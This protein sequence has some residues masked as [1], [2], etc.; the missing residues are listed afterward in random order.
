MDRLLEEVEVIEAQ[1]DPA[2]TE[3]TAI[4]FDSRRVGPGALFCC[5]PGRS[6]DGHDHAAAAVARGATALLTER[7]LVLDVT[8]VVVAPGTARPAMAALS[9]A[10]FGQPARSLLTVGVTGTNG[11][12]TVTH[13]L[14]SIFEAHKWPTT[15]IGTLDGAR[16]TPESPVLQRLLAEARDSGR[17][18]AAMEVSSHALTQARVDGIRFD[19]AVFTNLSHD[20]LDYHG[21]VDEYFAA[22]ASL[23]TPERAALAVV[24]ADDS[25]GRRLLGRSGLQT[26]GYSMAEVSDIESVP[27]RTSFRWRTHRVDVALAGSFHVANAL[28][29]ATTAAAL[30]V[31]EDVIVAGLQ[32]A[33]PVPGRFEVVV[34]EAP[35]TAVVDYAHTPAGLQVLLDS[36]RVLAGR[37]RVLCVFGCGGDRDRAKRPAMGA[38]AASSADVAVLTSDNPRG[39][40]PDAIIDEVLAGVPAGSDVIVR[41]DR[42]EAI[43][44]AVDM[45]DAGDVVVVAGKGHERDIE[46][47]TTSTP[48]DDRLV[49]A[50]AVARRRRRGPAGSGERP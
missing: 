20:H 14:A 6:G 12:T 11:K 48:F 3:V 33:A 15:V 46:I 18:A 8:Q 1:G 10:F 30:G 17:R 45:A 39:E 13:L 42:G 5:L 26:V 24:N 23:F 19:A 36:A 9:C 31:P 50:A 37:H 27:T 28:A 22:K 7:R 34:A 32:G 29:A 21:T 44:L 38:I 2:S 4:E 25:W 41:R 47:G 35:F 16:T 49:V 40:D 43:A